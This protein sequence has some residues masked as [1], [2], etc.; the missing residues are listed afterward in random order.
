MP[1]EPVTDLALNTI[2][3]NKQALVFVNTKRSAE[4]VAEKI[5][6]K[7]AGNAKTNELAEKILKVLSKPTKQCKRLAECVKKG[8]AFH[9]S[10]LHSKQRELIEEAFKEGI[11]KIISCTPTLAAGLDLPAFRTI[12]RDVKRFSFNGMTN[13]PVLEF[14]QM[15]V[16]Y[17]E[18]IITNKG[19]IPIGEIVEK[20]IKCKVLSFNIKTKKFEFKPVEQYFKRETN[21]LIELTTEKGYKLK[22][23]EEHP[24]RVNNIW[25]P[26]KK[27]K[28]GD[29]CNINVEYS[30]YHNL[31][32]HYQKEEECV[33]LKITKKKIIK[34]PEKIDV[35]NLKV[36]DNENYFA[37]NF[38]V[39]NCG[40]AG[41]PSFDKWGEAIVIA[42]SDA[43]KQALIEH[44]LL[45]EPEEIY[46]KLAVE[47]VLRV[48]L[49][50]LIVSKVIRTPE[51]IFDFFSR[52]FWAFQF[53]D[54]NKLKQIIR[55]VLKMLERWGFI[56]FVD[57][58]YFRATI[59]GKRVSELYLDPATAIQLIKGIKAATSNVKDFAWL[60]LL[61]GT[62]EM[63]PLLRVKTKEFEEFEQLTLKF[64]GELLLPEPSMF[65]PEY[66]DWL[67]AF[68][69]ASMIHDWIEEKDDEW[70]LEKYDCRPGETRAKLNKSDWLVYSCEELSRLLGKMNLISPLKKV[71]LRLKHGV[72]EELLP[73]IKFE[74]IGR[75][76]ARKLFRAGIKDAGDVKK[77][78]F[79]TLSNILT[80]KIATNLKKQVG[81]PGRPERLDKF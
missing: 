40:R 20:K 49:L 36:K 58:E 79:E 6:K 31:N 28:E 73:L 57:D 64:E 59:I 17:E 80:T 38:L 34:Y 19:N 78:R 56:Q 63:R 75:A 44:Y 68:K 3:I 30:D 74:G 7:S 10:G 27:I 66:N 12:I 15:C 67:N 9:H 25:K 16:P 4:A 54:M 22:L 81:A 55:K 71:R 60:H 62:L 1:N 2:S 47:P 24:V 50:S 5:S 8:V 70:I 37:S 77:A 61:S 11:I 23:T 46:S 65:E 76:R 52:T 42:N 26:A 43:E 21:K 33:G 53:K 51:D 39:H 14:L 41:R 35:Y 45:G 48:Y 18:K 69:T 72:K 13:I 32:R 29:K